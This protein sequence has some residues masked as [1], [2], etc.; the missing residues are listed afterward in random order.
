MQAWHQHRCAP[1][2]QADAA[3]F[4][5]LALL[6]DPLQRAQ[7]V[8]LD[9]VEL[10]SAVILLPHGE[11]QLRPALGDEFLAYLHQ[12]KSQLGQLLDAVLGQDLFGLDE[13][14][15]LL[16]LVE[17]LQLF[18]QKFGIVAARNFVFPIFFFLL[19]EVFQIFLEDGNLPGSSIADFVNLRPQALHD[20]FGRKKSIL[21]DS[22]F[23]LVNPNYYLLMTQ[24]QSSLLGYNNKLAFKCCSRDSKSSSQKKNSLT[25]RSTT[26]SVTSSSTKAEEG[27]EGR[28]LGTNASRI[29]CK[30]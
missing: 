27:K 10:F 12:A 7:A 1:T 15:H 19:L 17:Q 2:A 4:G 28:N 16:L 22:S 9:F 25:A 29:N 5:P 3:R 23:T 8:S 6:L 20:P 13:V 11:G 18:L 21:I 26:S 30:P 14:R 24:H